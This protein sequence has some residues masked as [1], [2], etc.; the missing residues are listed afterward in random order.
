MCS[1]CALFQGTWGV[2]NVKFLTFLKQRTMFFWMGWDDHQ[3]QPHG[4]PFLH[5][6]MDINAG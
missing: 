1:N 2:V 4:K 3:D 6:I 5:F